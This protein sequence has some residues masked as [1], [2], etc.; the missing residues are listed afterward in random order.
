ME[1]LPV[2][3]SLAVDLVARQ[4]QP[5]RPAHQP[6]CPSLWRI[7]VVTADALAGAARAVAPRGYRLAH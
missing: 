1:T 7:R 6:A 2:A 3:A 4:F 5:G